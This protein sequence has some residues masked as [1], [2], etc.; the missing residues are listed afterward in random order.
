MGEKI[1]KFPEDCLA[2][3]GEVFSGQYD[4]P[5]VVN[6]QAR[7]LDIG[8]NCGAFAVWAQK[9]WPNCEVICY[10]PH[11]EIFRAFLKPNVAGWPRI[12]CVE[13]AIGD[14]IGPCR[15]RPGTNTRLC[16]SLYDVGRQGNE[17]MEVRVLHPSALPPAE[18]IKIDTEGSEGYILENMAYVPALLAVEFHSE[19]L[20]QRCEAALAGKMTLIGCEVIKPGWGHMKWVKS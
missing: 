15:L 17:S 9:R 8:A 6:G 2:G 13:A 4:F 3:V 16:S 18:I 19:R 20:R 5:A 1:F 10:E 11:P 7:V 14:P 12:E